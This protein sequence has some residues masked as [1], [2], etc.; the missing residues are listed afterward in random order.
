MLLVAAD[1]ASQEER[2]AGFMVMLYF[3]GSDDR[4]G[5]YRGPRM[6]LTDNEK[7]LHVADRQFVEITF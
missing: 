7:T 6:E 3:Y 1:V 4:S 5:W 2:Q